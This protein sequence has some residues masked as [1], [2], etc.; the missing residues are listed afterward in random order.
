MIINTFQKKKNDIWQYTSVAKTFLFNINLEL[1]K[2]DENWRRNNTLKSTDT[3]KK[4]TMRKT[5]MKWTYKRRAQLHLPASRLIEHCQTTLEWTDF[6]WLNAFSSAQYYE[7]LLE[8]KNV[9]F[10]FQFFRYMLPLKDKRWSNKVSI[11]SATQCTHLLHTH[12]SKY[13]YKTKYKCNI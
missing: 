6:L 1:Q 4:K 10:F 2:S 7:G 5:Q 13:T 3:V 12:T 8:K 9:W 11:T